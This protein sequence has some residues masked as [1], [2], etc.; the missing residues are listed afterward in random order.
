[1]AARPIATHRSVRIRASTAKSGRF[2]TP[3]SRRPISVRPVCRN[4]SAGGVQY[5]G[6][7]LR[8]RVWRTRNARSTMPGSP[9]TIGSRDPA[10][11]APTLQSRWRHPFRVG[12]AFLVAVALVAASV[13]AQQRDDAPT[14]NLDEASY[15]LP[16]EN[17]HRLLRADNDYAQLQYISPDGHH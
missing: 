8:D 9:L 4:T 16:P 3:G 15:L 7:A 1:M 11:G 13:G 6:G 10:R 5:A 17:S 14:A 2:R 12:G